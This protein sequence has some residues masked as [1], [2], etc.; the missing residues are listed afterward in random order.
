MTATRVMQVLLSEDL[1]IADVLS[2][3]RWQCLYSNATA[4]M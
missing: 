4:G 1:V 3:Y 2:L